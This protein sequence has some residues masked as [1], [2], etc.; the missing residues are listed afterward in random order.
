[1]N[2]KAIDILTESTALVR[3][4]YESLKDADAKMGEDFKNVLK[5]LI[6]NDILF[7]DDDLAKKLH[8]HA[9]KKTAQK[10]QSIKEK[11]KTLIDQVNDMIKD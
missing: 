10:K 5:D 6:E 2:G 4:I 11:I 7:T 9:V 1:M 8:E 3:G